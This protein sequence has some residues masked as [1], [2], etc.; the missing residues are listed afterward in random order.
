M[1]TTLLLLVALFLTVSCSKED[2]EMPIL[3]IGQSYQG[4]Q[5]AYILQQG[6]MGYDAKVQHGLI[7]APSAQSTG[8]GWDNGVWQTIGTSPAVGTGNANTTA[9]VTKQGVG[10]YAAKLCADL[11]LNGYSDWYLPSR[12]ELTSLYINR[13]AVG[14]FASADYWSS[15]EF[16]TS[17]VWGQHFGNGYQYFYDK[18]DTFYVRA[19]R[20]F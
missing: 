3:T 17:L 2:D 5:I 6:D 15:T 9:I 16:S 1:K 20:A 18:D 12:D 8:I 4:G 10:S 19:V 11:V 7:A 13:V 14:G